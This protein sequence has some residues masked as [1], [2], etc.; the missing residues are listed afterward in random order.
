M[1]VW[2]VYPTL[3]MSHNIKV[4][5]NPILMTLD[6]LKAMWKYINCQDFLLFF[7]A[8]QCCS[9][10]PTSFQPL[11]VSH[12]CFN[13]SYRSLLRKIF[14]MITVDH[15]W[16]ISADSA[17]RSYWKCM[18]QANNEK[19]QWLKETLT[20]I[21]VGKA[22]SKW[23][24]AIYLVPCAAVQINEV[25]SPYFNLTNSTR[26]GCPLSPLIFIL[27]LEP[28]LWRVRGSA[29]IQGFPIGKSDHKTAAFADDILFFI[30]LWKL[31]CQIY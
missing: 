21:G 2:P 25:T 10:L 4:D 15:A 26:Q 1:L 23:I 3:R 22:F 29:D 13:G 30:H 5:V 12:M 28:F 27:T 16:A 7:V 14:T 20:H 9:S 6:L 31:R 8:S 24:E 19:E 11:S 17:A 18:W